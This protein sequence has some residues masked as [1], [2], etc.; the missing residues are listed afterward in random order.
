[1]PE[2]RQVRGIDA[3]HRRCAA[4]ATQRLPALSNAMPWGALMPLSSTA[5]TGDDTP[6]VSSA[7]PAIF[8]TLSS[9]TI[10]TQRL[11]S[12]S[13]ASAVGPGNRVAER[14]AVD[15]D[16]GRLHAVAAQRRGRDARD[17][18]IAVVPPMT[19]ALP[20]TSK[21][22]PSEPPVFATTVATDGPL[23]AQVGGHEREQRRARRRVAGA[24]PQRAAAGDARVGDVDD[25]GLAGAHAR[26]GDI[27]N[28]RVGGANHLGALGDQ[29]RRH[30]LRA[31]RQ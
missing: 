8:T 14:R 30:G 11:P 31:G 29:V 25:R 17:R 19:Q 15:D 13:K 6:G 10:E 4:A 2:R 23:D 22:K 3:H 26:R 7:D 12:A 24:H 18:R 21:V 28:R 27:D 20:N 16:V 9:P 5:A 1:M